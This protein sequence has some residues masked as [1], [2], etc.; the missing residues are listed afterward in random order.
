MILRPYQKIAVDDASIALDKHKNTMSD[1]RV[2][3]DK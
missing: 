2:K 3:H 1:Q